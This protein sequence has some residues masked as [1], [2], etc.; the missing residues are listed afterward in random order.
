LRRRTLAFSSVA[1]AQSETDAV[2]SNYDLVIA[3]SGAATIG[4]ASMYRTG[5]DI[6]RAA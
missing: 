4:A 6:E 2:H 1:V 5:P 3:A